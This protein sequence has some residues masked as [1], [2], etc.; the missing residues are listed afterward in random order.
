MAVDHLEPAQVKALAERIQA[1]HGHVDVLVND[2]W[3]AEVL[4]GGPAEWN[5]PIWQHDLEK[6]LRIVRLGLETHLVTSH[7]LLPLV[8]GWP[9]G[10]LVEVTDGTT[11]Y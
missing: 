4:K 8:V 10:R 1:E 6:G 11:D 3:R 9:G 2:I 5:T 7:Y